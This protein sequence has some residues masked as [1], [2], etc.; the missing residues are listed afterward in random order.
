MHPL[1]RWQFRGGIP[2]KQRKA[3][4][5]ENV[6]DSKGRKYDMPVAVGALAA[7][8]EIYSVG[9]GCDVRRHQEEMGPRRAAQIE[10][11]LV[12]NPACQEIVSRATT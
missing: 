4:L 10:P 8:R 11:V 2:E 9:V 7:N 12:D 5:F 3:F 1:V 6:T